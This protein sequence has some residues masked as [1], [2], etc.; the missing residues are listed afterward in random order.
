[1]MESVEGMISAPPIPITARAAIRVLAESAKAAAIELSAE[2]NQTDVEG[3]LAPEPVPE[4]SHGQQ[5]AG[6]YEDVG[7]D[8]PLQLACRSPELTHQG[9]QGNIENGV[10]QPDDDEAERKHYEGCPPSPIDGRRVHCCSFSTYE[11]RRYRIV[12]DGR[13]QE[14]SPPIHSDRG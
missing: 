14:V 13:I 7:I 4:C 6:E 9:G 10:V 2:E 12:I 5:Q 8:H 11:T 1:M 3:E